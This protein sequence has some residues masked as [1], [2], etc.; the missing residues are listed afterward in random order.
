MTLSAAK[1]DIFDKL[2]EDEL[3]M[4]SNYAASLIRN[5]TSHTDAYYKFMEA[6]EKMLQKNP[7]SD[8]EIDKEI[9]TGVK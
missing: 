9:H 5:R 2:Q 4:V 6:R 8:E 7:M 3:D 1:Q